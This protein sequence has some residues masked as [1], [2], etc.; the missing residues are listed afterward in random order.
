MVGRGCEICIYRPV[1]WRGN[2]RPD[3]M[4]VMWRPTAFKRISS[5]PCCCT[6]GRAGPIP[7]LPWHHRQ[8]S[9]VGLLVLVVVVA[10]GRE[11]NSPS[12]S[13][14]G[15]R[16]RGKDSR[17]LLGSGTEHGGV[18]VGATKGK[19]WMGLPLVGSIASSRSVAGGREGIGSSSGEGVTVIVTARGRGDGLLRESGHGGVLMTI[20][21]ETTSIGTIVGASARPTDQASN[22]VAQVKLKRVLRATLELTVLTLAVLALAVLAL[23]VVVLAV[24]ALA[25]AALAVVMLAVAVPAMFTVV[26]SKDGARCVR[27]FESIKR[28]SLLRRPRRNLPPQLAIGGD[29][30]EAHGLII[31]NSSDGVVAPIGGMAGDGLGCLR[32]TA[33]CPL[34]VLRRPIGICG[35]LRVPRIAGTV[36]IVPSLPSRGRHEL[37]RLRN[38]AGARAVVDGSDGGR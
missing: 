16:S 36:A 34:Q 21:A 6:L 20:G 10:K 25:V 27:H 4:L 33:G 3:G 14:V 23:A 19:R 17:G 18:L 7:S 37:G 13:G 12:P 31:P 1:V 15:R 9:R 8:R 22:G 2:A 29:T 28:D 38:T 5:L 11:T 26:S 35:L 24:V 32:N 30:V